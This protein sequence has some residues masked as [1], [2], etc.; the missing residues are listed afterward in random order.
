MLDMLTRA[1]S[2]RV[3]PLGVFE[4]GWGK[5]VV[6]EGAATTTWRRGRT[7]GLCTSI[8]L[9]PREY[10]DRTV[11]TAADYP[12]SIWTPHDTAYTLAAHYS[13]ALNLLSAASFFK[14]PKSQTSIVATAD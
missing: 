13:V 11:P 6:V 14:V 12:S 3:P 1:I 8:I 4:I 2:R 5:T 10:F 7:G 9:G